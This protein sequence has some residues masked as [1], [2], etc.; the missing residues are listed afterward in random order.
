MLLTHISGSTTIT[1]TIIIIKFANIQSIL[2]VQ[3][4]S[5]RT[6]LIL[7]LYLAACKA[8]HEKQEL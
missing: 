1:I 8:L 3:Y 4:E 7:S 6:S 5:I 2:V